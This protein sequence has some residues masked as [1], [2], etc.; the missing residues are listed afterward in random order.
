MFLLKYKPDVIFAIG[1]GPRAVELL[2]LNNIRVE[3]GNF[4]TIREVIENKDRLKN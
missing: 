3:T 2:R 4:Q 1:I